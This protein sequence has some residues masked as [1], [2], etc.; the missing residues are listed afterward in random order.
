MPWELWFACAQ[1]ASG[2]TQ[3]YVQRVNFASYRLSA[4]VFVNDDWLQT[5]SDKRAPPTFFSFAHA[6]IARILSWQRACSLASLPFVETNL[7]KRHKRDKN[8][9]HKISSLCL[10]Q[11]TLNRCDKKGSWKLRRIFSLRTILV[12]TV[13]TKARWIPNPWAKFCWRFLAKI[14]KDVIYYRN[15]ILCACCSCNSLARP[16]G[17]R[18]AA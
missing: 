15:L 5:Y 11:T 18:S 12:C 1:R 3:L 2:Q 10:V 13:R 4:R 7:Y 17:L 6:F 14:S 8:V 9:E 16:I